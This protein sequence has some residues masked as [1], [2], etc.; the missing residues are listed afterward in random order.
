MAQAIAPGTDCNTAGALLLL[1]L[2]NGPDCG[3][4]PRQQGFRRHYKSKFA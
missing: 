1:S 3:E 2:A 4:G